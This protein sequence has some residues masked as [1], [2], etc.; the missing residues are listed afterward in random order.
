[1]LQF[2]DD[3]LAKSRMILE[4]EDGTLYFNG[5][6]VRVLSLNFGEA[7]CW[8]EIGYCLASKVRFETVSWFNSQGP[9]LKLWPLK[10]ILEDPK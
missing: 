10:S 7:I 8:G 2:S 1:M 9:E 6:L 5:F 3:D 4:S